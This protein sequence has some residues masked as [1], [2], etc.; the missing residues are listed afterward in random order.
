MIQ[1]ATLVNSEVNNF[2]VV[3]D[4]VGVMVCVFPHFPCK[5]LL[6]AFTQFFLE[7]HFN[8]V[9]SRL[10][11]FHC[12]FS[13]LGRGRRVG[14]FVSKG[15]TGVL[16]QILITASKE[17]PPSE[18]LMLQLHSLLAKV[19]PKGRFNELTFMSF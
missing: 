6:P 9:F 18:E 8:C 2:C 1:F 5:F 3:I 19:G 12:L 11:F 4:N 14:V 13:M 16:F 7:S 15:G 17:L 10:M